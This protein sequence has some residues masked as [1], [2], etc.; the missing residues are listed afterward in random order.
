MI[1]EDLMEAFKVGFEK[2]MF[3]QETKIPGRVKVKGRLKDQDKYI[4]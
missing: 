3:W 2:D 4:G 1:T